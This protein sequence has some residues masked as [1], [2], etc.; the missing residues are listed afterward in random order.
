[1]RWLSFLWRSLAAEETGE[2]FSQ[3]YSERLWQ[4]SYNGHMDSNHQPA[5][6]RLCP[7]TDLS[8]GIR[9]RS[10]L[11]REMEVGGQSFRGVHERPSR[12][13]ISG[14]ATEQFPSFSSLLDQP[15]RSRRSAVLTARTHLEA[16]LSCTSTMISLSL[17]LSSLCPLYP[18][19]V[20]PLSP[21][22]FLQVPER[23][24][25]KKRTERSKNFTNLTIV[26]VDGDTAG[27]RRLSREECPAKN[28]QS[29]R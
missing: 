16:F 21:R 6:E 23:M 22:V 13:R 12:R 24:A 11:W 4:R 3:L 7:R 15:E 27:R 19:P 10:E 18:F 26:S 28:K 5:R 17:Y 2:D 29:Q 8:E 20:L 25:L 9:S 14:V 1:M